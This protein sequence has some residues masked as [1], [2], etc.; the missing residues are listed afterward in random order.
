MKE[1]KKQ[2]Q[3]E[4]SDS[5]L[6]SEQQ[7]QEG[8]RR[9]VGKVPKLHPMGPV[10]LNY[11]PVILR[12]KIEPENVTLYLKAQGQV[13][14]YFNIVHETF[15]QMG[16]E[17]ELRFKPFCEQV[18]LNY[19]TLKEEGRDQ[20]YIFRKLTD[21]LQQGTNEERE[22]CEVIISYFIQKCEVFDVIAE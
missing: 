13:N 16:R 3:M 5:E 2:F 11:D 7:V 12:K 18:K 6:L 19:L 10:D 4:A 21:W 22:N 1:I 8:V 9:I 14:Y 20:P 17:G 15:Q